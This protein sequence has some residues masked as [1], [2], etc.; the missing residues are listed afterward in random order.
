[1][2]DKLEELMLYIAQQ[3]KDDPDFDDDKMKAIL[4]LSDFRAYAELGQ[5][6]TDSTYIKESE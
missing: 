2:T 6:I 5:S 1:M 3:S 4:F